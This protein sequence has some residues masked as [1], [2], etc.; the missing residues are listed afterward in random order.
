MGQYRAQGRTVGISMIATEI[1]PFTDQFSVNIPGLDIDGFALKEKTYQLPL[2][3]VANNFP[4]ELDSNVDDLKFPQG[5]S[6]IRLRGIAEIEKKSIEITLQV[7]E[8]GELSGDLARELKGSAELE[9]LVS[10][11]ISAT[12]KMAAKV[13]VGGQQAIKGTFDILY[14]VGWKVNQ[15]V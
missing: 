8:S 10:L 3:S 2:R 4:V 14:L 5:S 11:G 1:E 12:L 9:K 7:N 15:I 13:V 6:V